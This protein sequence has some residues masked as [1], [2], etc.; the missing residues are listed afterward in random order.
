[1]NWPVF[2]EDDYCEMTATTDHRAT[3]VV[4]CASPIWSI[5]I[6]TKNTDFRDFSFPLYPRVL[7]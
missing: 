2:D 1:M 6:G 5:I 7:A 3:D 4:T